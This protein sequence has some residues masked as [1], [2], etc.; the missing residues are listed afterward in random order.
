M[1]NESIDVRSSRGFV[2]AALIVFWVAAALVPLAANG[3]TPIPISTFDELRKIG[4]NA[5]YPLDAEYELLYDIDASSSRVDP[6]EP[7]G[8]GRAPFTGR[9][10]G[11]GGSVFVVRNLYI[12]KPAYGNVGLFGVV[13]YGAEV[14]GIG[15]AA[16]T[17]V[18]DYAVGTLAGSNNGRIVNCYGAGVV[19]AGRAESNAG[20]LVGVNS[21]GIY[22]SYSTAR[23]DGRQNVG[24]L[25]GLLRVS[26]VGEVSRSFAVGGV[27]GTD[28]VGGLVG[29]A[30][31]GRIGESFSAGRVVGKRAGSVVGGLVGRDFGG[32]P[33]WSD[34]GV[35]EVDGV[36]SYVEAV[37]V[38]ASFW[39]TEASG[40]RVSAGGAGRNGAAMR[41]RRTFA[42][43]DFDGTW[44]IVDGAH[45]PQ[46]VGMPLYTRKI[47]YAVDREECGRIAVLSGVGGVVEMYE[48][49]AEVMSG[50]DGF[51]VVAAPWGGCRFA[52]WGDGIK[53][54][55]RVDAALRD[56]VFVAM[57]ERESGGAPQRVYRYAAGSGGMLRADGV[58]GLV[59]G[60]DTVIVGDKRG[61]IVAAV[62]DSGYR[63]LRWSDGVRNVVR[64][65]TVPK[66]DAPRAVFYQDGGEFKKISFYD[67]LF[68]IGRYYPLDGNYELVNDIDISGMG[69]EP[70]G[71][72][73][74]PFTGV[75]RGNGHKISGLSLDRVPAV[76]GDFRGL[77]GYVENAVISGV[78]VDGIVAGVDGVGVLAGKCINSVIDGCGVGGAARGRSGVGGLVGRSVGSL[79]SNSYSTARVDGSESAAGGLVGGAVGSFLTLSYSAG[80][81]SGAGFVGGAV[82]HG[83]GGQAQNCYSVGSV[84]GDGIVGGFAGAAA[85]GMRLSQCYSSGVVTGVGIGAGGFAGTLGVDSGV[86]GGD[87]VLIAGCYWDVE[88]SGKVA[89]AGGRGRG[90]AEMSRRSTYIGWDFAEVWDI[91]VGRGYPW[92]RGLAPGSVP[93]VSFERKRSIAAVSVKPLIRVVGRAI[94]VN[95]QSGEPIQIRLLDM[96]GKT[97]AM[98]NAVGSAKLFIDKIPSGRYIAEASER[99]R[100][101]G[102][103]AIRILK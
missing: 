18:G 40:V 89:S 16:D 23:V 75:F 26:G 96:R 46:F 98:Y 30:F 28:F 80:T 20:G 37:S 65:D 66:A 29:Q 77:F 56:T 67:D 7:I 15:I 25:V 87:A 35:F 71:S 92:L 22:R 14:A 38:S 51:E 48:Y 50:A 53:E 1:V 78:Y 11:R 59:D 12:N 47:V 60:I 95:A 69:F 13:G 24:G 99:G 63:F 86:A 68:L 27:S 43:W 44:S 19:V 72:A 10:F 73:G 52:G 64:V 100:R 42:G 82:G 41:S 83:G 49:G 39:D 91:A 8:D 33:V 102:V 101:V 55:R 36:S 9:F 103:S 62:P 21:G 17:I 5:D 2:I 74:A 34:R 94:R 79:I 70:I 85:D 32:S 88:R 93:G 90:T 31:G 6:F 84:V 57:F 45:Y 81:V 54:A 4:R 61:P 58:S 76:G 3:V 97:V